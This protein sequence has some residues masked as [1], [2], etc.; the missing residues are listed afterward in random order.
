MSDGTHKPRAE[1]A[2]TYVVAVTAHG[3]SGVHWISDR[4]GTDVRRIV[5]RRDD[6]WPFK[7]REEAERAGR[8][9]VLF[10]GDSVRYLIFET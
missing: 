10:L 1:G 4:N 3:L 6:A 5:P 9:V 2:L 7:D 8:E